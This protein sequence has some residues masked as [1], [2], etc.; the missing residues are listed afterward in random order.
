MRPVE[1]LWSHSLTG[2]WM[3]VGIAEFLLPLVY[4]GHVSQI[5]WI[6]SPWAHQVRT[7]SIDVELSI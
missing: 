3:A 1:R 4:A 5:T 2:C 7:A 6:K